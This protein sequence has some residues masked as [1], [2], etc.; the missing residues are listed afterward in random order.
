MCVQDVVLGSIAVQYSCI[1]KPNS[2]DAMGTGDSFFKPSLAWPYS[3]IDTVGGSI[4][5]VCERICR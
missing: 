1:A 4:N 5:S 3:D 2:L